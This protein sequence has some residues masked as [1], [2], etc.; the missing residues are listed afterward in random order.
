MQ[1][2]A[3]RRHCARHPQ[4]IQLDAGHRIE[5]RSVPVL[6]EKIQRRAPRDPSELLVVQAKVFGNHRGVILRR[7]G[8]L[9]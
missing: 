1:L 9:A 6:G 3:D 2:I 7:G 5:L 4:L 8:R